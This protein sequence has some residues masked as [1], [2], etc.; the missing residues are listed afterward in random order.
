MTKY[1]S[2]LYFFL[3][4]SFLFSQDK[5]LII[6]ENDSMRI[7]I[8]RLS[9]NVNTSFNDYAPVITADGQTM[10][11]TSRRPLTQK[12]LKRNNEAREN[13][14]RSL[15]N[16]D[17]QDWMEATPLPENINDPM[18]YNSNIA[19]SN[20]GQRLL[21]YRDDQYGNGDIFESFLKGEIWSDPQPFPKVINSEE[22]ES[23]ASIA[24]DGRKIYFVSERK[25]GIG[26]RDIWTCTKEND[27]SWGAPENLST[28]VNTSTDEESVFI[29]PDGKT[30]YFSSKGH[31]SKGGYDVFKTVYENGKW[32]KPINLG[33]PINTPGDD[34]FF[35]L[36]ADGQTGYYA[37]SRDAEEKD[38]YVVRFIP[39]SVDKKQDQ[40]DLTVLKGIIRDDKTKTPL[41]AKIIITDNELNTVV[42][43]FNSNSASGK[44]LIPLPGGKNYGINVSAPGYIFHSENV[45]IAKVAGYY[46]VVRDIDLKKLETGTQIVLRNIFFD[47]DK[48]T[49]KP[50]SKS[51]LDRLYALMID[52][53][54]LE[55][56]LSGHT[57]TQGSA[58][59]NQQLS[60]NRAKTV[61]EYL[62]AMGIQSKRFQYK[63]YGEERP[64]ISDAAIAKMATQEEK[65]AA[66]ANNRRTEIKILKN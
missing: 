47:L 41:E 61:V 42:G 37:S 15:Y 52:N 57:D 9:R 48:Y 12:E 36:T 26:G 54:K 45:G 55:I 7:E 43:E 13:I 11:F 24:P 1:F 28:V 59:Y 49:L 31:A 64:I 25:G 22:H 53:P 20:D 16:E 32:S 19:I 63:G 50:E 3:S 29:H 66:H 14:Y 51:E 34:L 62:V 18:R 65:D 44:Y 4:L 5:G 40:P 60:E 6:S 8:Q 56:E 2:L 38:L 21:I 23:S 39:K 58:V 46:E 17:G 10:F 35:V 27:G 30:L 33:E